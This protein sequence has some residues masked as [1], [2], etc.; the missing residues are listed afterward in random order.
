MKQRTPMVLA[1]W[2]MHTPPA[3][4]D[5]PNSP[6]F[7]RQ[8][9]WIGVLPT[10]L[11]NEACVKAGCVTG[12][13]YGRPEPEGAFTG[14]VSMRL[15]EKHKYHFVLCG[16]SERRQ[17]H[18]ESDEFIA[19][20]VDAALDNGIMAVLC[21]GETADERELGQA[22]ETVKRQIET[23]FT[24]LDTRFGT[25]V[26]AYEPVWAIG[27]GKNASAEDAQKMHAY[28]RSLLPA[29]LQE[30][31][32]II[33]GGSVKSTN[34]MELIAQPD[35]DGFLVGSA[36]LNPTEFRMI[37]LAMEKALAAS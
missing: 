30:K 19:D 25:I 14:D 18:H 6:Y 27:T 23:V 21:V 36:S 11:D 37:V 26:I 33:Y 35:I 2:K 32:T 16:H 8:G 15:L 12:A 3:G 1:N 22:E 5:T 7:P 10:L 13:Q 28:I 9:L 4:W 29:D 34:A 17:H 24:G 31:T 20:Q